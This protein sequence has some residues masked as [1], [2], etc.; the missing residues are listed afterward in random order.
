MT[1]LSVGRPLLDN[2]SVRRSDMALDIRGMTPLLQV[3]DMAASMKVYLEVLGFE[4]VTVDDKRKAPNHDWVWLKRD[5]IHLMLNTA[6]E[7]DSR[8]A[9]PEARHLAAH[10]DLCLYFDPPDVHT[11]Y[12]VSLARGL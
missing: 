5:D 8:P 9:T 7:S 6:Y 2:L 11:V 3:F 4:I 1:L 12:E 10:D